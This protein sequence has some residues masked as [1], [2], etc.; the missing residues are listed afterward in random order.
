MTFTRPPLRIGLTGGIGSG[1]SVVAR[2]LQ[3]LGAAVMDAD[4]IS[5][6]MT[7]PQGPAMPAIA[8]I[9]GSEF[10][11][12]QGALDRERM[13]NH[14]FTN[15]QAKQMLEAIIH[16]LVAEEIQRQAAAAIDRGQHIL[17]FDVPLLVE[18]LQWRKQVDRILVID[19]TVET[20]IHRVTKRDQLSQEAV[21]RII[22][23][24]ATRQ[25][26]LSAADWVIYN[27]SMSLD[28]LHQTVN[29]L[30][31][32]EAGRDTSD[33]RTGMMHA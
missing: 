31:I 24:Q 15:T 18:S 6:S 33:A 27:E 26:R 1:K 32:F 11:N 30:P 25:Q 9:F 13:R 23:A 7:A 20:Q 22:F 17:V 5:R 4:A 8:R 14:V 28:D 2:H 21:T 16:P 19:C 12:T 10:V 3:T 29:R